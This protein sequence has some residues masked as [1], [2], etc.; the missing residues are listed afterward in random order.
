MK[1]FF[2]F[3]AYVKAGQNHVISFNRLK[4][5]YGQPTKQYDDERSKA[6]FLTL[7]KIMFVPR[8]KA[9]IKD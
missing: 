2:Y 3:P 6:I 9:K 8:N 1:Y 4:L 5:Q 7:I